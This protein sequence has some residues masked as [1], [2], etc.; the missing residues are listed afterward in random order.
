MYPA[1]ES[2]SK[3]M[4]MTTNINLLRKVCQK[5]PPRQFKVR[6]QLLYVNL[7]TGI[8]Y[9]VLGTSEFALAHTTPYQILTRERF[10]WLSLG[11]N[12]FSWMYASKDYRKKIT[13]EEFSEAI[14]KM[15]VSD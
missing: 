11:T 15:S 12:P 5:L 3:E 13:I 14:K 2:V 6:M 8:A 9:S 4:V 7:A 10:R 1:V